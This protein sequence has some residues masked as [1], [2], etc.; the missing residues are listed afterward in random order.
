[1]FKGK[2]IYKATLFNYPMKIVEKVSESTMNHLQN[3][4]NIVLLAYILLVT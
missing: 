3:V 2:I 1:M 4:R